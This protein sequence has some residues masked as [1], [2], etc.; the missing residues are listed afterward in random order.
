M[1]TRVRASKEGR[2]NLLRNSPAVSRGRPSRTASVLLS[3]AKHIGAFFDL[4]SN[5]SLPTFF[6]LFLKH[7]YFSFQTDD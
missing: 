5:L 3:V 4:S 7:T 2:R 6:L 1:G